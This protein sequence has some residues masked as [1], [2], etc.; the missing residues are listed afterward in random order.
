MKTDTPDKRRRSARHRL[1]RL[2]AALAVAC[3]A[4]VVLAACG[5]SGKSSSTSTTNSADTTKQGA[6]GAGRFASLQACLKKEG[7]DLPA[8]SGGKPGAGAT[9][10]AG[11]GFK[12][13]E[14]VSRQ[15]FQEALKKCGGGRSFPQGARRGLDSATAKAALTK[16]AACMRENGVNL[17]TPNTGGDGPVFDTKGLD[18]SSTAFKN[19]QQKCQDDL[20]GAFGAGGARPQGGQ[21]GP[22]GSAEGGP[23]G[24]G[25]EGAPGPPL[26]AE[27]GSP[28]G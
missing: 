25:A 17:P 22:A 5:S 12:L 23:P 27:G 3:V 13:P 18:T 10:G 11:G 6:S 21:G 15:K 14:G 4:V 26:G 16:Y 24:G 8:P 1:H 7:I 9:P 19:A 2:L 20:K 28:A